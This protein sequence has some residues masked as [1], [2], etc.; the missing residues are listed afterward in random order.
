[1]KKQTAYDRAQSA[2]KSFAILP[3]MVAIMWGVFMTLI[4]FGIIPITL[5]TAAGMVP[6]PAFEGL[7]VLL[8]TLFA[9]TVL[10]LAACGM[11]VAMF[12]MEQAEEHHRSNKDALANALSEIRR[13]LR[14]RPDIASPVTFSFFGRPNAAARVVPVELA[15]T[16]RE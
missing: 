8:G 1:M 10:Y 9:Y 13:E 5:A 7:A 14:R 2:W 6:N 16:V 3:I 12:Q 15:E 4:G 11:R